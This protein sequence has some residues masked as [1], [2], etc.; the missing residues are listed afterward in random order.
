MF[1]FLRDNNLEKIINSFD[2]L[3]HLKSYFAFDFSTEVKISHPLCFCVALN[4]GSFWGIL[5][6]GDGCHHVEII[7]SLEKKTKGLLFC[8]MHS[9]PGDLY[10]G[11][12]KE[13]LPTIGETNERSCFHWLTK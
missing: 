12:K 10:R 13:N 7:V 3:L 11:N 5:K 2:H 8:H 1:Q 6:K 9:F 4:L